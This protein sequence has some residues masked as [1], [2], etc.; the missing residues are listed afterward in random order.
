MYRCGNVY[1]DR[2]CESSAGTV[3]GSTKAAPSSAPKERTSAAA[4]MESQAA[5]SRS[6][7]PTGPSAQ[8]QPQRN[9][10]APE[11]TLVASQD[12][13]RI[14]SLTKSNKAQECSSLKSNV[15]ELISRQRVGGNVHVMEDLRRQR[16]QVD[17]RMSDAN[18]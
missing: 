2:Q 6:Q 8:P 17:K 14:E 3:I 4:R 11:S 18:C 9:G 13:A 7:P 16:Q 5:S 1:Q 12:R 15:D 10:Y